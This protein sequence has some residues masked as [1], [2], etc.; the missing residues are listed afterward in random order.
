MASAAIRRRAGAAILLAAAVLLPGCAWFPDWKASGVNYPVD[1]RWNDTKWCV[2][3]RLKRALAK[4]SA[5]FGPVTVHSTHRWPFENWRKGGKP[6]SFHLTCRAT[7]FSV[8]GEA[9][10]IKA[11]LISLPE[12]GG[13]S[14]YPQGFFHI[15]T[16]PRRTW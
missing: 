5:H 6:K 4:V 8:T 11:F 2:P 15:D 7:D 9:E 10:A 1:I 12:V 16:G 3:L 13:Y 14:R